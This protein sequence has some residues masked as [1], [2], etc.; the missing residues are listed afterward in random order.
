MFISESDPLQHSQQNQKDPFTDVEISVCSLRQFHAPSSASIPG[1]SVCYIG[2]NYVCSIASNK[3]VDAY[4]TL[5]EF[6]DKNSASTCYDLLSLRAQPNAWL[7]GAFT[8]QIQ[9]V[10]KKFCYSMHFCCYVLNMHMI[11]KRKILAY[12]SS[13][14]G[15]V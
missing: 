12:I 1:Q 4:Q 2:G 13:S 7:V 11:Y 10:D 5:T 9:L 6:H 8:M 15:F 14:V 3:G